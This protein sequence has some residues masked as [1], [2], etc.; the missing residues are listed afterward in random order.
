MARK[1]ST[2]GLPSQR[3]LRAGE[4]IRHALAELIAREDFRDP[5]LAGVLVT[6]GEVRCSPDLK[7]ANIFVTPLGDDTE[8]GRQKLAA[9]LNRASAF[10]RGRLGREIELK[11]TPELHFIADKSY[12]E[13]TAI[14]RLLA[15]PRV[16]RDVE[17]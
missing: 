16:R 3:Q 4:I 10:L 13:A 11:F 5:E 17:G 14:D 12:D 8:E 2:P 1:T 7:R 15:D 9:A 6:V